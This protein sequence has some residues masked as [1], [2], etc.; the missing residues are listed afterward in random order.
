MKRDDVFFMI[1][2]RSRE[3][4]QM[5]DK[6]FSQNNLFSCDTTS[7]KFI[8]K[9]CHLFIHQEIMLFSD[10]ARSKLET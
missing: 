1:V 2:K 3:P 4:F 8:R 10:T 9:Y 7:I 6:Y 5:K